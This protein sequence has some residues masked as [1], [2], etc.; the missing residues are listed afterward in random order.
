M[1]NIKPIS[2]LRNYTA[3]TGAVSYGN[4]V[5]LTKNGH[6]KITM[7]DM[8]ELDDIEKELALYKFKYEMSIAEQSIKTSGIVEEDDLAEELGVEL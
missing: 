6:G 8:Q 5:Y 4:R 3:I 1:P 2:D 7:I